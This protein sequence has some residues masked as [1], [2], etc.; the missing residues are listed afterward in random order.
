MKKIIV[1]FLFLCCVILINISCSKNSNIKLI[2]V[3]SDEK[4]GYINKKGEYIINPQFK[5]ADFFEIASG[6]REAPKV[7]F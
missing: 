3:Q 1:K 7:Q 5:E 4:W 2:P 6:E